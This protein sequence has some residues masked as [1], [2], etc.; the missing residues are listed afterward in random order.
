M[1][2]QLKSMAMNRP[3][4]DDVA[5]NPPIIYPVISGIEVWCYGKT[6]EVE[7]YPDV[8]QLADLPATL[9]LRGFLKDGF[10]FIQFAGKKLPEAFLRYDCEVEI[11]INADQ[12]RREDIKA[13]PEVLDM[14]QA[15]PERYGLQNKVCVIKAPPE[16]KRPFEELR[17]IPLPPAMFRFYMLLKIVEI[18]LQL[19]CFSLYS[20]QV[21]FYGYEN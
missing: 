2:R 15:M 11:L 20:T 12:I 1:I 9:L 6:C 3:G 7:E 14:I 5:H 8:S 19:D 13:F 4:G 17:Q 18:V 10:C 21:H 16:M